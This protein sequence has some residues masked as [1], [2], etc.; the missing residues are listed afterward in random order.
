[1][2]RAKRIVELAQAQWMGEWE[3]MILFRDPV[4]GS[5]C[6]LPQKGLTVDRVLAKLESKREEFEVKS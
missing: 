6:S 2:N 3:S 4:T 1:V 5:T